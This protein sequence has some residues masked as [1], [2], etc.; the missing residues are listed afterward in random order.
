MLTIWNVVGWDSEVH[1]SHSGVGLNPRI[2]YRTK[3]RIRKD[4]RGLLIAIVKNKGGVAIRLDRN[5]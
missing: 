5:P 1:M 4:L 3:Y 2:F